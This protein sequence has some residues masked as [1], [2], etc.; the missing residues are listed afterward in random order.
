MLLMDLAILI[1]APRAKPSG[2]LPTV[3]SKGETA[4]IILRMQGLH[5]L[6]AKLLY[7]GLHLS[8]CMRLR[9]K[10]IDFEQF[11]II[12]QEGKGEKN[13]A[14]L[15]LALCSHRRIKSTLVENS[16]KEIMRKNMVQ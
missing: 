15:L 3:S 16:M 9:V 10:Y 8:E 12:I 4:C 6:M 5:Q 7:G 14:A 1:H 11:N 13:R 2:Y